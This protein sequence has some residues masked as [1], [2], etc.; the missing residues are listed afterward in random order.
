LVPAAG[1]HKDAEFKGFEIEIKKGAGHFWLDL[2]RYAEVECKFDGNHFHLFLVSSRD[3][4]HVEHMYLLPS[5]AV[6]E[7]LG[8][9]VEEAAGLRNLHKRLDN[10]LNAQARLLT[11]F[12]REKCLEEHK[13]S[14]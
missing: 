4:T 7:L 6:L 8:L 10:R 12:I 5:N 3:K 11:K 9:T 1:R 2:V 13:F 14:T